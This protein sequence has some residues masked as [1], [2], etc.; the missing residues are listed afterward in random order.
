MTG[1]RIH[2]QAVVTVR[3]RMG[4][5]EGEYYDEAW[6]G[7]ALVYVQG[8]HAIV[9]GLESILAGHA[10]GESLMV[11][12]PPKFAHGE[13]D[14]RL[15]LVMPLVDF[16]TH[17]QSVIQQGFEFSA[18]NPFHQGERRDFVVKRINEGVV[19]V[20]GNHRL[21]GKTLLVEVEVL[22]VRDANPEEQ[23][24]GAPQ[25]PGETDGEQW[26]FPDPDREPL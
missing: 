11:V 19:E 21:A 10:P 23:S 22:E 6:D 9:P 18:E 14:R 4:T 15:E 26:R 25:G 13:Y 7:D 1:M 8:H 24:R 20:S 12:I 16:P 2:D 17:L 5:V 3:Y